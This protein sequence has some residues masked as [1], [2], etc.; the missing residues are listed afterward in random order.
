MAI[1]ANYLFSFSTFV[2]NRNIIVPGS[3]IWELS[4]PQSNLT[5][6]LGKQLGN[7]VVGILSRILEKGYYVVSGGVLKGDIPDHIAPEE[8]QNIVEARKISSLIEGDSP[9]SVAESLFKFI[10]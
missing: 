8:L 2:K 6:L 10:H 1:W 9:E 7:T 4:I 3:K 5:L